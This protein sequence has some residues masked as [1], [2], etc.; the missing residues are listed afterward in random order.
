MTEPTVVTHRCVKFTA[1]ALLTEI[2]SA[3]RAPAKVEPTTQARYLGSYLSNAEAG[4]RT[5]LMEAPY[6][7]RHFLEEYS[8]YYATALRAPPPQATRIHFLN[9]SLT[10]DDF[11]ALVLE[12]AE[13]GY[14]EV[15][16]KLN[17]WYLGFAVIRPLPSAPIGRTL[18]ATYHSELA[19][20]HYALPSRSYDVHLA[21]LALSVKAVPFQ[22]QEQAVGACATTAVWSALA[23]VMRTDGGRAP[24]PFAVT[25]A[26]TKHYLSDRA[27]PAASG[28]DTKQ[29]LEAIRQFGYSP[30]YLEATGDY[31]VFWLCVKTYVRSGIPVI[32]EIHYDGD[33]QHHAVTVVGYRESDEEEPAVE[34]KDQVTEGLALRSKGLTRL[35][36]HDDRLGPY[37]RAKFSRGPKKFPQMAYIPTG[38]EEFKRDADILAA[39][40]PLYP[41]LRLSALDLVGFAGQLLPLMR[42]IVGP[43]YREKLTVEMR[44]TMSGAYL[45]YLL[46]SPVESS[47][48]ANFARQARL[49]RY[50]AVI[51]FCIDD[52]FCVDVLCDTT[53]IRR[54]IPE[55]AP[56]IAFIPRYIEYQSALRNYAAD[57]THGALVA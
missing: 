56:V 17:A 20:R 52:E 7:D 37:A 11:V 38:Y 35:F 43:K 15:C 27:F 2:Q 36:L 6:V 25:E 24:T 3:S 40:V 57:H 44:F 10:D 14:E 50:V 16:A 26:A 34:L 18:L 54:D 31:G 21:G 19:D 12:A 8:R 9:T 46:E 13:D 53:D 23:R 48:A 39:I 4:A 47:R 30:A 22:Q 49:P 1:A 33:N 5:M 28:L 42:Y 55:A 51:S 45:R 32:L 29:M 41:K